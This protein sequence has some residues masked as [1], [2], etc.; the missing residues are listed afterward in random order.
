MAEGDGGRRSRLEMPDGEETK[1]RRCEATRGEKQD[2]AH[3]R[4]VGTH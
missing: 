1:V 3:L 4:L 2:I